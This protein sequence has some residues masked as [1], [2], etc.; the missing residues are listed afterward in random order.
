MPR[1]RAVF[2][3]VH[4]GH[5]Q[6]QIF[7][8]E[9]DRAVNQGIPAQVPAKKVPAGGDPAQLRGIPVVGRGVGGTSPGTR[10]G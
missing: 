5:Q 2:D 7:A 8:R 4:S 1:F 3:R 9:V 6:A 10:P